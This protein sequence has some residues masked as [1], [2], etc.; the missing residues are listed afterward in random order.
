MGD[1]MLWLDL[2]T[3]GTDERE[4]SI[5]EVGCILTG[6]DLVELARYESLAAPT[7]LAWERM[8]DND[9]V[10]EMHRVSGL[11]E[12]LENRSDL[13]PVGQV[14]RE[15]CDWLASLGIRPGRVALAGSGVSHFDRRFVALQMPYLDR[16]V[17]Y[18]SL[19][20]GVVRR[21]WSGVAGLPL[22]DASDAGSKPHRALA[23]VELHLQEARWFKRAMS[24]RTVGAGRGVS[25][26]T[27]DGLDT[28]AQV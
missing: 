16:Y 7:E 24:G 6:P 11:R 18:W 12:E 3:T 1:Y 17:R 22:P 28:P 10:S 20:V 5:V 2:E 23:D 4:D 19:D 13:R 26:D 25:I 14:D 15:L 21:F 9:V 8:A 27:A